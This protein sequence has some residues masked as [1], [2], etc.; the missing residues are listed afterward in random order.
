[1]TDQVVEEANL[2]KVAV[3]DREE[4]KEEIIKFFFFQLC[5]SER[6]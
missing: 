6:K 5:Q 2:E 3:E 4:E 1:M